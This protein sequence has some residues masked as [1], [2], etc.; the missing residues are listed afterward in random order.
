MA[1]TEVLK[2]LALFQLTRDTLIS[3]CLMLLEKGIQKIFTIVN[4]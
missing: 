3:F 4:R 2:D 1:S